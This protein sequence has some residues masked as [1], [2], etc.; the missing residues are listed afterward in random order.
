MVSWLSAHVNDGGGVLSKEA[1][2]ALHAPHVLLPEDQTFPESTRFGYGLGWLVG[3][4][5]GRRIVDHS[6][7]VDGFLTECVLLP[8]ER[9]GIVVLTN[10]WSPLG[11]CVAYRAI[12]ELLTLEPIDWPARYRGRLDELERT[13][14]SDRTRVDEAPLPRP[15]D[16]YAGDY[17]H[18]GYGRF[19]VA[20]RD[21]KLVPRFGTLELSLQHR[22]LDVFELSWD[23]LAD[24]D[25]RFPLTFV[26]APDGGVAAL[27]VP[28]EEAV[29]PIR[30]ER[31]AHDTKA[32]DRLV[33][34]DEASP[35]T[36]P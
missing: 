17:E 31:F 3:Q 6:G 26:T 15:V 22:T 19:T 16:A 33:G 9:I 36:E 29:P 2:T 1:L 34:N 24:Q 14:T 30:F 4:Y 32:D 20:V 35:G 27:E 18:P 8:A 7:G 5:R 21:G 28:F 11:P 10:R 13:R 12:D 23:E 25:I